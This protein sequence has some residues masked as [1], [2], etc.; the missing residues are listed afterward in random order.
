[1]AKSREMT[2]VRFDFGE[3]TSATPRLSS[4]DRRA[5]VSNALSPIDAPKLCPARSG[6]IA[7]ALHDC[8]AIAKLL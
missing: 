1:M 2:V 8:V 7:R 5:S 6:A 4:S 3:M